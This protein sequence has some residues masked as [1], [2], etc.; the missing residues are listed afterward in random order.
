VQLPGDLNQNPLIRRD[1]MK[2]RIIAEKLNIKE[3][4]MEIQSNPFQDW[5]KIPD[6][7]SKDGSMGF[8]QSSEEIFLLLNDGSW[9]EVTSNYYY[10]SN[11][12]HTPTIDEPGLS[13]ADY[14]SAKGIKTTDIE[15]VV[16][17]KVEFSD[18]SGQEKEGERET[19][20]FPTKPIDTGKIRRRV[21]D[22]LRKTND[23]STIL[24]LAVRLGVKI[25]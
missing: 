8:E 22:A 19:K 25:D 14:I 12:A 10:E 18:W 17:H 23:E 13:V 6:F 2:T 4:K 3:E 5:N 1:K 20:V 24:N 21:E 7:Y 16:L 15:A 9:H 11:Y